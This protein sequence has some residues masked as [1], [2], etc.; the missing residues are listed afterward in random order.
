[1]T[2]RLALGLGVLA[3]VD[4][5]DA[6]D[7]A[8]DRDA[9]GLQVVPDHA[10]RVG[11]QGAQLEQLGD[12]RVERVALLAAGVDDAERGVAEHPA[13]AVAAGAGAGVVGRELVPVHLERRQDVALVGVLRA[14]VARLGAEE[15]PAGDPEPE[16]L[17]LCGRSVSWS[18]FS[19][20]RLKKRVFIGRRRHHAEV[21]GVGEQLDVLVRAGRG[22]GHEA[23]R[24]AAADLAGAA[25]V[26]GEEAH[27]LAEGLRPAEAAQ[28]ARLVEAVTVKRRGSSL[29]SRT[30]S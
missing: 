12:A 20:S 11:I 30:V 28:H 3:A 2:E 5:R 14:Q 13:L 1:M 26:V 22:R 7:G 21:G 23:E 15:R 16:L 6:G 9:L 27:E 10:V 24:D 29:P 4:G 25:V 17:S 8:L 18:A 19:L